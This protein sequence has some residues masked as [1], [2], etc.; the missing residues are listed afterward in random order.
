MPNKR[1]IYPK[2]MWTYAQKL[3]VD[4]KI[5]FGLCVTKQELI[6]CKSLIIKTSFNFV[7]IVISIMT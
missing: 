4:E 5:F 7:T 3:I 1:R 6:V 2:A